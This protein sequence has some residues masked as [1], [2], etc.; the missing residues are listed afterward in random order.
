MNMKDISIG[1]VTPAAI[2]RRWLD[3]FKRVAPHLKVL[4]IDEITDPGAIELLLVW[5]HQKGVLAPFENVKLLYSLGAGVDHLL[6]DPDLPKNVPICRIVDPL[7]SF[8]MSN[9]IIYAVLEF[10]RRMD[11]YRKDQQTG[12]W[13][14]YAPPERTIHIGVL[15]LGYLGQDAACKLTGLGFDVSGYSLSPK[16]I[17]N[18]NCYHGAQLDSFLT[19]VNVLVCTVPYT[20]KTHALLN[21]SLFNKL[22]KGSYLINV[23]RGKVQVA[24]DI[25]AALDSGQLAGAFLDVFETEPLPSDSPFWQHPKVNITP[26]IASIT[27]PEAGVQQIMAN[28]QRLQQR[29]PL[30]NQVN[31]QKGY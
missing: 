8:S 30:D 12:T 11:K 13:D 3:A 31:L 9:Y 26:H 10:Q 25:L 23:A 17:P 15:G 20:K 22:P 6:A 28:W 1:L 29:K 19:A 4:L 18:I 14:H 5:K 16:N 7:L 2:G 24:S 27:N 21:Q